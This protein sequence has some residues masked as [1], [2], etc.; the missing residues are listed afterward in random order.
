MRGEVIMSPMGV[1]VDERCR[2][3]GLIEYS[4]A[5]TDEYRVRIMRVE[6]LVWH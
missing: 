2:R 3:E 4:G 6:S 1:G 5:R